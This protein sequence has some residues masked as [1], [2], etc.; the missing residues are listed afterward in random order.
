M[1]GGE[2]G[3]RGRNEKKGNKT[4]REVWVERDEH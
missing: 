4:N 2:V 1:K 3:G